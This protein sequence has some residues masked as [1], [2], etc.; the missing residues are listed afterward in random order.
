M[1]MTEG[2]TRG[3]NNSC[4]HRL[5]RHLDCFT[6]KYL[7]CT[8]FSDSLISVYIISFIYLFL[9]T[10]LLCLPKALYEWE[11]SDV[12][13]VPGQWNEVLVKNTGTNAE[14]RMENAYLR[15][16][17]VWVKISGR[18]GEVLDDYGDTNHYRK[19]RMSTCSVYALCWCCLELIISYEW[20]KV[21]ECKSWSKWRER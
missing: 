6:M 10:L 3:N 9:C 21:V 4:K 18:T 12:V 1:R 17:R 15:E 19:R 8:S 2:K 5:S 20:D 11:K 13:D 16:I 7:V 14:S